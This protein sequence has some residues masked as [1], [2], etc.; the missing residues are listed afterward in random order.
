[1]R[2]NVLD[3]QPTEGRVKNPRSFRLS[4]ATD[5]DLQWLSDRL[6]TTQTAAIERAV[7]E[8]RESIER[9]DARHRRKIQE[10]PG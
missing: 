8:M 2:Y 10:I 1:M 5:A 4:D 7:R 6:R 9:A 3:I